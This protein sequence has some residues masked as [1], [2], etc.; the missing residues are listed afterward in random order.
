M[1][2]FRR[3]PPSFPKAMQRATADESQRLLHSEAG[4]E[5]HSVNSADDLEL[6]N[7]PIEASH[8]FV[9]LSRRATSAARKRYPASY[10]CRISRSRRSRSRPHWRRVVLTTV[11]LIVAL[12]IG[13]GIFQPSYSNPPRRYA[14]LRESAS[15]T[16][17]PGR[18]NR[19]NAR[20]YIAASLYDQEGVLVSGDWGD[21]V[22][23]L[24]DL[25]G[26]QNVYLSV[27]ENNADPK[28]KAALID[29]TQRLE[30]NSSVVADDLDVSQLPHVRTADG[31][32]ML[33]RIAFLAKVRNQ[34]LR[35]LAEVSST[36]YQTRFDKLL[37]L[38][39]VIFDPID[40]A[41][42]LFSTNVNEQSGKTQYLA[43]CAVDF[44]NPLKFYDTFATRD[45]EG[46]EVGVPFYPWFTN[47]GE[48]ASRRDVM[49][50]KDAVRVRSCW[51]G[52]IAF[53]ARW[54]QPWMH[55]S[56][57]SQNQTRAPLRFRAEE[58]SFWEA[59]ECCLVNADMTAMASMELEEHTIGIFMNPYV[60]VAY[61]K[62][63]FRWLRLSKRIEWLYS[64]MQRLL[65][66]VASRPGF[67]A[68]RLEKP[69]DHI[70]DRVWV[71]END[72]QHRKRPIDEPMSNTLGSY[73]SVQ[74]LASPGAFCGVRHL[75][76]INEHA[77]NGEKRWATERAPPDR[78]E[79]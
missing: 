38:N 77:R 69:G 48:A 75:S 57:G 67:N 27:Y 35:P 4:E 24:V 65:N 12:I 26:P 10:F 31:S 76:F 1:P 28:A 40:A 64:P 58:E 19:Q 52:M 62:T 55:Q 36:A 43:A 7:F 18:A 51:G 63:V 30:C 47:A 73:R 3:L 42:L 49:A 17:A 15:A 5:A 37:Y 66:V 11:L 21:A 78:G 29:F 22:L 41:N 16:Q 6:V 33:S 9:P 2:E 74:R 14:L 60:R 54:F 61:S 20:V 70:I 53:E 68:R 34:A 71:W 23:G 46:F 72:S 32:K 79:T 44:I 8:S 13:V 56:E 39:D 45:F 59:S 50:Q 25:L